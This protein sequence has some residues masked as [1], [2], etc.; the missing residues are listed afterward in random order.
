MITYAKTA[1]VACM[2]RER[3]YCRRIPL[4]AGGFLIVYRTGMQLSSSVYGGVLSAQLMPL[5][6]RQQI[7][8]TLFEIGFQPIF[9][10]YL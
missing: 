2:R 4:R 10:I 5:C 9:L 3:R 7:H 8:Y 6:K 1:R